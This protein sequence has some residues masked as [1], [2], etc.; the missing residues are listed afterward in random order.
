MYSVLVSFLL[1]FVYQANGHS[2]HLGSCPVVESEPNFDIHKFLGKWY[3]LEK[4]NTR[5]SCMI[6]NYRQDL[7]E[8]G[9]FKIEQVSDN[10]LLG[11]KYY[12]SGDLTIPNPEE[13]ARMRVKF[14]RNI[15]GGATYTVFMT[16]HKSY[17]GIFTCQELPFAHR[18]SISILSKT[19]TLDQA[20]LDKIHRRI[21]SFGF[22]LDNLSKIKQSN[23][24]ET[25]VSEPATSKTVVDT[26]AS[27]YE[28][29]ADSVR[30]VYNKV[31]GDHGTSNEELNERGNPKDDVEWL[32]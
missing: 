32:P 10:F 29:V 26:L 20:D 27:G 7:N 15:I 18:Q 13:T 28:T 11:R 31:R 12:Y 6:N 23:C 9:K 8:T 17:A 25:E 24:T 5:S 16:D 1:L 19:K 22:D 30:K 21:S 4:T 14:E 3:V 2:Y